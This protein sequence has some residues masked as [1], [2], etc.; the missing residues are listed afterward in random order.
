MAMRPLSTANS[1]GLAEPSKRKASDMASE[2]ASSVPCTNCRLDKVTCVLSDSNRGKTKSTS[3]DCDAYSPEAQ[4]DRPNDIP[5]SLTFEASDGLPEAWEPSEESH[6]SSTTPDLNNMHIRHS[7]TSFSPDQQAHKLPRYIRPLPS[8]IGVDDLDYLARKDALTIPSDALRGI[9]LRQFVQY[10]HP[11]MPVLELEDFLS[12]I[13]QDD[14]NKPISLLLFQAV[15]FVSV[16]FVPIESLRDAGFKSRKSARK[17]FFQR[18]RMLYGLDCEVD[19]V[20]LVQ[21]LLLMTYWYESPQDIKDTWH[22]MGISLSLT[23][24]LGFHRDP[25]HLSIGLR[26]KRRQKRIW[27]SCFMRDRLLALG[28]RRPARIRPGDFS[29]PML[30]IDDFETTSLPSNLL[31]SVCDSPLA[32]DSESRKTMAL[33]CIEMAKLCVCIGDVLFSQYSILGDATITAE[34]DAMTMVMPKHSTEQVQGLARCDAELGDWSQSMNAG[35]RYKAMSARTVKDLDDTKRMMRLHQA[36][37]NM[38]YLT[39]VTV[40][41]RPHALQPPSG[42]DDGASSRHSRAKVTEAATGMSEIAYDLHHQGHLRYLSTSSIP[43]IL[44]ATLS[45]LTDISSARD[46]VRF[47]S[48]GRFYQC[49]QALEELRDMYASADHAVWFLEAVVRKSGV[50]IPGLSMGAASHA[51]PR[52]SVSSSSMARDTAHPQNSEMRMT[53]G[54]RRQST[55]MPNG[56]SPTFN[57][58]NGSLQNVTSHQIVGSSTNT[59]L[60]EAPGTVTS[61]SNQ[62]SGEQIHTD[63]QNFHEDNIDIGDN[64]RQA[65]IDFDTNNGSFSV[66]SAGKSYNDRRLMDMGDFAGYMLNSPIQGFDDDSDTIIVNSNW[67]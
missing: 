1:S 57:L 3:I 66:P 14:C 33:A 45:H 50:H 26:T 48:I 32:Q 67:M 52:T 41:H 16:T 36:Q 29:V 30:T 35:C 31:R 2:G 12:R 24:V 27:W 56:V 53:N 34:N 65:L 42:E 17:I 49:L 55:S 9:L 61:H 59:Q 44:W 13:A 51:A 18:A 19:R 4:D 20:S 10:V 8:H 64:L 7:A 37:L 6:A 58:G 60:G 21:A 5:V 28:I 63:P 46:D 22:W 38:I 40:L 23:Q 39:T 43:A 15:M 54:D 62:P 25:E 47:S 11:F